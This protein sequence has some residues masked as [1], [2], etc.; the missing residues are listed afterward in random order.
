M[1]SLTVT[2]HARTLVQPFRRTPSGRLDLS[3]IDSLPVLRCNARTLHVF[4]RGGAE[5]AAVIREALSKALVTYYPLAG[6]LEQL[7]TLL[8]DCSA[9]GVWFVEASADGSVTLDDVNCFD[10]NVESI[11]Y[12]RLLPDGGAEQGARGR[13]PLVQMQ[14]T[15]FVTKFACGGFVIGLI[16]CHA[17][18]DGL[19]AAQ[20]LS[21][22]GEIARGIDSNRLSAA[23]V[24]RRDFFPQ[25][26]NP[27]SASLAP[28][29]PLPPIPNYNLQQANIDIP[30][31]EINRAKIQ[32]HASTGGKTCSTFEAVAASLWKHRSAAIDL[33]PSVEVQL[34]FF[35][36]CRQLVEPPLPDGF[37]GNCFFPVKVTASIGALAAVAVAGAIELIQEA[38]GRLRAEFEKYVKG[39][40]GEEDPFAPPLVYTTLFISEWGRLGFN[41]VDYGWGPPANV[42]PIQ[43]SG[44]IPVGIVGW[45]PL[46]RKGVR[47][48]TWCVEEAH[49]PGLIRRMAAMEIE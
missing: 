47:L 37:Y 40:E 18:C 45:L 42:V 22:V 48:M 34:V 39:E 24:W 38:K 14:A 41:G 26:P 43:G 30:I 19:G 11:P 20:F 28:P 31:D 8:V 44:I 33:D 5:A 2:R 9:E 16:F 1:E 25:K 27:S 3:F 36:N 4:R 46:P 35:A 10:D 12:D 17:I 7:E 21:A 32:F 23:P 15:I 6:R 13:E 49:R 29:P